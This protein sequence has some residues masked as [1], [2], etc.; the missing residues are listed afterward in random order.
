MT[1][2]I[3]RSCTSFGTPLPG[4]APESATSASQ[5]LHIAAAGQVEAMSAGAPERQ[6]E[7]SHAAAVSGDREADKDNHSSRNSDKRSRSSKS[8]GSSSSRS[9]GSSSTTSTSKSAVNGKERSPER[10]KAKV[11]KGVA[12]DRQNRV[13]IAGG[14]HLTARYKHG[15]LTGFQMTCGLLT[16]N[17]AGSSHRC[18]KEVALSVA[19]SA[20]QARQLLKSWL[21]M[22]PAAAS[23]DEHMSSK[24]RNLLLTALREGTRVPEP[25]LDTLLLEACSTDAIRDAIPPWS[26]ARRSRGTC[27]TTTS[28]T[29]STQPANE[30]ADDILGRAVA[31]TYGNP[32]LE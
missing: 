2:E 25:E 8:S 1:I 11:E 10:K 29:S 21:L 6:L 15:Q 14:H 18:S 19:G 20:E 27:A 17:P 7:G 23:R 32:L 5:A 9:S 16:H 22:G 13:E 31:P 3:I 30:H 24:E 4:F 12:R 26:D 28:S